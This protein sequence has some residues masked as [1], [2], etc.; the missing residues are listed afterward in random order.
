MTVP[1]NR[2]LTDKPSSQGRKYLGIKF[3]CCDVYQR[4]YFNE[5]QKMYIGRCPRCLKRVKIAVDSEKGTS[6]RFFRAE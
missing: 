1:T 4:V 2:D 5:K 6:H 3:E